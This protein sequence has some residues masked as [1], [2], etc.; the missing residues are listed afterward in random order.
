M[1][2]CKTC[3][4][5]SEAVNT[6]DGE[7][8]DYLIKN[9]AEA[10][11][12]RNEY[13]IKEGLLSSHVAYLKSGLAMISKKGVAGNDQILKI[14]LPGNYLGLQTVLIEKINRYSVKALNECLVC[15]IDNNSFKQIL[16][17]NV[18]FSNEL[19]YFLCKEEL[20]YFERFVN[21]HQKQLS[22]KVADIILF[23]SNIYGSVSFEIPISRS[24]FATLICSTRE[25]VTRALKEFSDSKIIKVYGKVFEIINMEMLKEISRKG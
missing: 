17:K 4:I 5:R 22:G 23:F 16:K 15:F 25:S 24:D 3:I 14:V 19:L 10:T 8:L 21:L 1:P 7:E 2:N 18:H 12:E 11:F 6:L 13:I 9:C 20:S